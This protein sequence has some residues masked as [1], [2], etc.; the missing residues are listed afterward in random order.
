MRKVYL[1]CLFLL[2]GLPVLRA[3]SLTWAQKMANTAMTLW[4]DTVSTGRWTYEQG[5]VW[6]GMKSLWMQTGDARY[7]KYVQ[8]CADHYINAD[9][10]IRTYKAEDYN[11]DNVMSG[12]SLL[13][14]YRVLGAEKYY[15][16]A[17]LLHEQLKNQP[18]IPQG[19]FWHKKRYPNQM[20]LDGLYMGEPFYAEYASTFHEDAAFDDIANQFILMENNA[21][22]AKT[23]LLYH[24]WDQSKKE[25]WANPQTGLSPNIWGRAMG[26]YGMALVDVLDY[27]PAN[28]PKRAQ[29]VAILGRLAAAIQKYQDAKSGVWYQVVDKGGEKGN[30]LEASASCMFVYTLAKGA[31]AGYLPAQ[32]QQVAQTG[33]KGIIKEFIST[34]ANGQVNLNKVCSVAG[35]G[36]NPYRDGS[37]QYYI[38][39]KVATNDLKGV[40]AF[41]MASV[42]VDRLAHLSAG[43]VKTVLLDSYFNDE[44]KKDITGQVLPY[45][46]KW[47]GMDNNGFS[48][49]G[50]LFNN[51]GLSTQTLYDAPTTANLKKADIYFIVDPDIPKENPDAKYIE[52]PHVKAISE[53]VKQG[54]VL[55]VLNNDTGNAEFK[56]LNQL[57]AKFGM[58]YKE[59]SVN[60]VQGSQFEQGAVTIPAGNEVFKTARKVYIKEIST[61]SLTA[62]AK[63]VLN[64]QA[65]VVVAAAKYGKG[66]VL[67]VGDPWFYNEYLDGRKLPPEMENYKAANDV[68]AWLVKQIPAGK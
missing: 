49:L 4:S 48:L 31:R 32:Y 52:Q 26:W 45:H 2:A 41:I 13:T 30:Y 67:A 11:I 51:Y 33:Y 56:H 3:Q 62:P 28:H 63:P 68:I 16:A 57:M 36:G 27:M 9:G 8:H 19:G 54:G 47:N 50:Y 61:F 6:E 5:V 42:E 17:N 66:T 7:F 34:D 38:G 39:E 40:G 12:R 10:S 37:Y 1:L 64:H 60:H 23:G 44:R 18:R 55:L 25:R 21:R 53:W 14:L 65:E 15:K 58:Q 43:K 29:L 35:L 59:N 24:G 20:W 22:N 46:Y